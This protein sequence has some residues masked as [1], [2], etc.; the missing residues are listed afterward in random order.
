MESDL[1]PSE[2]LKKYLSHDE[3]FNKVYHAVQK[4][5]LEADFVAHNWEHVYRNV[6]NAINIGEKELANMEVVLPASVMHDIGFLYGATGP[7]HTQ[8]GADKLPEYLRK[9]GVSY[10]PEIVNKIAACISTHKGS[11]FNDFPQTLEAKVVAD[12]DLLE[13]F[14]A[15]GAYQFIRTWGEFKKG[16]EST[17]ERKDTIPN[18]RLET[19]TAR[20]LAEPG[21]KF[22]MDFFEELS[23]EYNIYRNE[24]ISNT[25]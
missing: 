17:I 19:K 7:T 11:M 20:K 4:D 8:I 21:R 18:L 23:K 14:G 13:K 16:I 1:N 15:I 22:V 24:K 25:R 2:R 5:F 3:K 9:I 6:I 12:A 10:K